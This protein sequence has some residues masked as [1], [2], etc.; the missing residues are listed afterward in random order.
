MNIVSSSLFSNSL[1]IHPT[2]IYSVPTITGKHL[3]MDHLKKKNFKV[4]FKAG[5][6]SITFIHVT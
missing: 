4:K 5:K 1:F 3:S 6:G 2:N